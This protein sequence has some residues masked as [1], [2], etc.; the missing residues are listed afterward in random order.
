[1]INKTL[2]ILFFLISIGMLV[3]A[4]T[5]TPKEVKLNSSADTLQYAVGAFIGQWMVKN[6]LQVTNANV[7]LAGMDD[8]LKNK[9]LAVADSTIAPIVSAYQLSAQNE[10]NQLLENQLFTTLK[11]KT[12]VGVLPNGV[13]Y[14]VLKTGT[15]IRPTL[16][17]T[18]EIDAIGVLPDGTVFEDT[19]Q[20]KKTITTLIGNLIPGLNEA[21]Q[22]MPVGATWRIFIPSVLGYGSAGLP[23]V[24]PPHSALVFDITLIK[25]NQ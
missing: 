15:G 1:M 3:H 10:R 25:V 13:N 17:D 20:K 4:Q 18:I 21:I 11:G 5:N 8:A 14:I 22:L 9:A 6:Q 12:G 16:K 2:I 24:I 7:F 19:H 23:N